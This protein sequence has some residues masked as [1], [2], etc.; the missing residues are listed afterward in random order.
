MITLFDEGFDLDL[1][2]SRFPYHINRKADEAGNPAALFYEWETIVSPLTRAKCRVRA[3]IVDWMEGKSRV[4][5]VPLDE[6]SVGTFDGY[7]IEVNVPACL[8]GRNH[9]LVNG[10]PR[11]A[12]GAVELL[13]HYV[14]RRG[15]GSAALDRITLKKTR[16]AAVT[17]TFLYE[18]DSPEQAFER[19]CELRSHAEG[20]LNHELRPAKVKG[21]K[22]KQ[23]CFSVGPDHCFT[24]YIK[25]REFTVSAYIKQANV[26]DA[27]ATFPNPEVEREL[28][29]RAAR[30]VRVEVEVHGKWLRDNG[31][32]DAESWRGNP[33]AY[34]KVFSLARDTLRLNE[35]LRVRTPADAIVA[36][37]PADHQTVLRAHLAGEG[38]REHDLVRLGTDGSEL[39]AAAQNKRVSAIKCSIL[40]ATAVEC[41]IPWEIQSTKLS[42]HLKNWFVFPGEFV[43]GED[44]ELHLFSRTSA[45]RAIA[46]LRAKTDAL[47]E[48][49]TTPQ[50][51]TR[52]LPEWPRGGALLDSFEF[53]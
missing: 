15:C 31:L 22:G 41:L 13:R 19:L 52:N 45:P 43:P 17:L 53:D 16:L 48:S 8:N 10:V 27:F 7:E 51:A 29:E 30:T 18:F 34:E 37:L 42:P 26:P 14:A 35:G 46:E 38:I 36:K 23:P 9:F 25:Q 1:G 21:S 40:Q 3:I 32:D 39:G 12:E 2:S 33:K 6:N 47:V 4:T 11:A 5:H 50:V 20:V 24:L 49:R 28:L 44:L